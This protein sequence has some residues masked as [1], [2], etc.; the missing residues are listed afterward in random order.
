MGQFGW[1]CIRYGLLLGNGRLFQSLNLDNFGFSA[2][3]Q[4]ALKHK[5]MPLLFNY[6]LIGILLFSMPI[7]SMSN[8]PESSA[9]QTME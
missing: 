5:M 8:L 6:F 7:F 3:I 1:A 2:N 9:T 4:G